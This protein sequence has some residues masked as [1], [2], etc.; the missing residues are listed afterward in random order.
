MVADDR[1]DSYDWNH[2]LH[3][4]QKKFPGMTRWDVLCERINP[5]LQ[6][7]DKLTLARYIGE[8]LETSIRRNSTVRVAHEDW[9]MSDTSVLEKLRPNDYKVTAY[10]MPDEEGKPTD[11]YIFQG[12][13]YIDHVEKV[14]TYNRVMAEQ[15]EEDT[16][17]YIEQRKKIAKF[18]K[19]VRDHAIEQVGILKPSSPCREPEP[20][21]LEAVSVV[22]QPKE[23]ERLVFE[24]TE[25]RAFDNL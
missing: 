22:R 3:P 11:V 8:R 21:E 2:Q 17:N 1:R 10:Y 16:V 23:E 4:N 24:T 13:K 18:S 5:T 7:L 15:T 19:Y 20:E 14:Q 9:W 12:D 6:P 25:S